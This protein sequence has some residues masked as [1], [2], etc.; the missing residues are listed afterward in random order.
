MQEYNL[1]IPQAT[2][3]DNPSQKSFNIKNGKYGGIYKKTYSI[4]ANEDFVI[5]AIQLKYL[6]KKTNK[7]KT[8]STKEYKIKVLKSTT[9]TPKIE[10][11]NTI[12]QKEIIKEKIIYVN[13]ELYKL[14]LSFI[15][16]FIIASLIFALVLFKNTKNNNKKDLLLL[17]SIKKSTSS[18]ELLKKITPFVNIDTNLDKIIYTLEDNNFENLK[19]IKKEIIKIL[20]RLKL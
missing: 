16:G 5:P 2:I 1:N 9:Q 20:K 10:T 4:V 14:V 18:S 17:K 3:Y 12:K 6:D 15:G 7:I 13:T 19:S 11:K 8:I